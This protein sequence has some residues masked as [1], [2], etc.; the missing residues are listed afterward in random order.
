MILVKLIMQKKKAK[1]K[2]FKNIGNTIKKAVAVIYKTLHKFFFANG[3]FVIRLP[4]KYHYKF[5]VN[6]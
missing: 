1:N 2:L 3:N 5:L 6:N 4:D